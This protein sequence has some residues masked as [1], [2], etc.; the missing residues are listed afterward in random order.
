[1]SRKLLKKKKL[2][3]NATIGAQKENDQKLKLNKKHFFFQIQGQL[4]VTQRKYCDF[5]VWTPKGINIETVETIVVGDQFMKNILPKLKHFYFKSTLQSLDTFLYP[6]LAVLNPSG[7]LEMYKY[8]PNILSSAELQSLKLV[9]RD[10]FSVYRS[11]VQKRLKHSSTSPELVD[12][13]HERNMKLRN[14]N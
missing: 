10:S 11:R 8:I 3:T 1:M 2:K 5:I 6:E 4:F 14:S 13:R 7:Y 9:N 12:N